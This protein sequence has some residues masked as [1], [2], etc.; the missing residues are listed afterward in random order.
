MSLGT[1]KKWPWEC[2]RQSRCHRSRTQEDFVAVG[3]YVRK[4][5]ALAAYKLSIGFKNLEQEQKIPKKA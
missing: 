3:V 2:Q 1:Q 4:G 5:K